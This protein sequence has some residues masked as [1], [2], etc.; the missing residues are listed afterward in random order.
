[1]NRNFSVSDY[2]ILTFETV[3]TVQKFG[4]ISVQK[5]KVCVNNISEYM[6][7]QTL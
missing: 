3:Q 7:V 4:T 2:P 6:T 1:M 5:I